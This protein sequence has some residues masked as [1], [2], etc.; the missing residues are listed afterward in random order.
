MRLATAAVFALALPLLAACSNDQPPAK[1]AAEAS[2]PATSAAAAPAKPVAVKVAP[3]MA[4]LLGT[5]APALA[6][7]GDQQ[8][9]T[10]ITE[11]NYTS[12]AGSCDIALSAGKD[13]SFSTTCGKNQMTL[14]PVFAPTGEGVNVVVGD[15]KRQTVLR[16]T[17]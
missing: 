2:T 12:P 1:P 16:C 3:E 6:S 13:G 11:T 17:R 5:W 4:P 9:V 8:A 10:T 7:C 15:G 14:T